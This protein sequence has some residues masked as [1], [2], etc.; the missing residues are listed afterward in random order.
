M[1]SHLKKTE[2]LFELNKHALKSKTLYS[3]QK[4]F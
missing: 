3:I 1:F 2:Y 4:S